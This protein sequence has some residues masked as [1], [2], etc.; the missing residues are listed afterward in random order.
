MVTLHLG[1]VL[2]TSAPGL[3]LAQFAEFS[4]TLPDLLERLAT[5]GGPALRSRL[6]EGGAPR[7]YLTIFVDGR[8]ARFL[9]PPIRLGPDSVV[10]LLPAVAGG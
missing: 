7:R 4:G 2:R 8:D 9:E 1:S 10:D 5:A 3:D 6:F